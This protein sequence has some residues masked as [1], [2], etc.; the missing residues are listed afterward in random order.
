MDGVLNCDSDADFP[1]FIKRI[2]VEDEVARICVCYIFT[3]PF[4]S[5]LTPRDH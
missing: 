4:V 1:T 5:E 2:N 3:S